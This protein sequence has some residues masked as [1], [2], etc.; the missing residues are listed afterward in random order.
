[1]I[2]ITILVVLTALYIYLGVKRP[3]V[4]LVTSLPSLVAAILLI[5]S[6]VKSIPDTES[7]LCVIIAILYFP[8]TLLAILC[9]KS[10][11]EM[12][13]DIWPKVWARGILHFIWVALLFV[14][15]VALFKPAGLFFWG[16]FV[17][18]I[19]RCKKNS[20]H[21]VTLYIISTIGASIRQNLPLPMALETAAEKKTDIRARSLRK[22]S[23]W[24]VQ[25]YSVSESIRNGYPK[26]SPDIIATI[27]AAENIDQLPEAFRSIEAEMVGKTLSRQQIRPVNPFYPVMVILTALSITMGL[28]IFIIP[29]FAEVIYDMSDGELGLPQATQLLFDF[30]DWMVMGGWILLFG[31]PA[32]IA[33]IFICMFIYSRFR[34]R[35]AGEPSLYFRIS[36]FIKWHMP[37]AHWF[38]LNYSMLRVVGL[39]RVSLRAGCTVN[40]AIK[41]TLR[42]DINNCFRKR[43]SKWLK[44]IEQGENISAAARDA[45]V[46]RTIAWAF[47]DTINQGNTGGILEMLE[48]F[49]RT[50]YS[51][52]S[53]IVSFIMW[54]SVTLML[55]VVVGYITYAMI[56][57]MITITAYM[58][59]TAMP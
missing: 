3:G 12:D 2:A 22:I 33:Q 37:L 7:I 9:N 41:N 56:T 24:L 53:N 20:R 50:N 52:R 26:C 10:D 29:T 57:P 28:M 25:G 59:E 30:S 4:A 15:L 44:K 54:P 11:S 27:A 31:I 14:V 19:I 49:H 48:K 6:I 32:I 47:D 8:L 43:L 51:Y 16:Y 1:M 5:G 58:A 55:A 23:K 38:E 13:I 21:A 42:L 39:L 40:D 35:P 18:H 17:F 34:K 45:K 46:G 36:D